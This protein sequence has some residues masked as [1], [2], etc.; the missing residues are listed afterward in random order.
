MA[1]EKQHNNSYEEVQDSLK[2]IN[3]KLMKL[4]KE[5]LSKI[6][7]SAEWSWVPYVKDHIEFL[8]EQVQGL[9]DNLQNSPP[10]TAQKELINAEEQRS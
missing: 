3:D 8:I 6:H 2:Q 10:P 9:V 4:S 5:D 1:E 7:I